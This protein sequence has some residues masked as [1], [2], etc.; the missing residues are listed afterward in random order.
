MMQIL[1]TVLEMSNLLLDLLGHLSHGLLC[2]L[3]SLLNA[4]LSILYQLLSLLSLD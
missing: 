1:L 3:L 4:F 2:K